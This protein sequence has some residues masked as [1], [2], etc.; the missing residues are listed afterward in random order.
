MRA[1]LIMSALWFALPSKGREAAWANVSLPALFG[2]FAMIIAV[3][4]RPR[5]YI[6]LIA[7]IAVIGFFL[8]PRG[9]R[10][11]AQS[12]PDRDTWQK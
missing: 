6:P 5:I 8:R 12:R 9:R 4:Y 10:R 1:G 2:F 7:V 3:S 11:S